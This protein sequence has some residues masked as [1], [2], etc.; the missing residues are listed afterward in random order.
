[1]ST[2]VEWGALANV[3]LVGL[4]VGAGLPALYAVGVWALAAPGSRTD[5]GKVQPMRIAL[6][7]AC[8]AVNLSAIAIALFVLASGGH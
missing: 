7:V 5:E 3:V 8:F 6:A 1:M 2:Y 4:L